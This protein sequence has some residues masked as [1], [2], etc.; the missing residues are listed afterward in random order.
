MQPLRC[1]LSYFPP[2][3][4]QTHPRGPGLRRRDSRKKVEGTDLDARNTSEYVNVGNSC[5]KPA[6]FFSVKVSYTR[7]TSPQF[8][9]VYHRLYV[10][11][12][13]RFYHVNVKGQQGFHNS[14][15][16]I[17]VHWSDVL[18]V[19]WHYQ[20]SVQSLA[21]WPRCHRSCGDHWGFCRLS[22]GSVSISF[23]PTCPLCS[24]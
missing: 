2:G 12:I 6:P 14:Y 22:R 11:V 20:S 7:L 24:R 10:L 19:D 3:S 16:S 4:T 1:R 18:D 15:V 21:S 9:E 23:W 8:T 17:L 13:A 5:S